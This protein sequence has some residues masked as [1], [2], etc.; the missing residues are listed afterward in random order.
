[1][2]PAYA[3][4]FTADADYVAFLGSHY[5]G[6]EAI[7]ASYVALFKKFLNGAAF[8]LSEHHASTVRR[9]L[10]GKFISRTVPLRSDP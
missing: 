5:K 9:K 7:A 3:S 10:M 8:R 2:R 4:V 1:V 6:R